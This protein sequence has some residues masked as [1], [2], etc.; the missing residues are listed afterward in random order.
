MP[1]A[2][3]LPPEARRAAIIQAARPL[4]ARDGTNTTTKQIAE[5]CGIAEGTIFRVFDDKIELLLAVIDSLT[6][7]T[8]LCARLSTL[9]ESTLAA[10]VRAIFAEVQDAFTEVSGLY[11][12]LFAL[13]ARAANDRMS[14]RK[15]D[16]EKHRRDTVALN[17]AVQASLAPFRDEL[18]AP[19]G[20]VASLI[21]TLASTAGHGMLRDQLL[22][23]PD[24]LVEL[25]LHGI[26]RKTA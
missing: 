1:R 10:Q 14:T 20:Q 3:P 25:L 13:D 4:I 11:A 19:P 24:D 22:T 21:V 8:E 18:A 16:F 26:E 23:D 7:P 15:P 9:H 6:D 17:E 12:A 2:T 5:A